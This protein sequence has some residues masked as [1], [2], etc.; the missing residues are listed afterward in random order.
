MVGDAGTAHRGPALAR[1]SAASCCGSTSSARHRAPRHGRR[2]DG[3]PRVAWRP[4]ASGPPR[5]RRRAGSRTAATCLAAGPG[6]LHLD[7]AGAVRELAQ[8]EARRT[9]VRMNDGASRSRRGASGPGTMAYDESPGAGALYRL[10]PR[11]QLHDRAH[12]LDDRQRHRLKPDARNMYLNDSGTGRVETFSFDGASGAISERRTLVESDR[13][14]VV[15]GRANRR[16]R[17]RR[18]GGMVGRRGR[19]SRAGRDAPRQHRASGRA[20][21]IVRVRR[22]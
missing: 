12:R 4:P 16:C 14:G 13:P 1:M 5:R 8:P 6:F 2:A 20:P 19:Q 22:A 10:E 21:D 3:V 15:P 11:R 18:L 17:R 7:E 9:D